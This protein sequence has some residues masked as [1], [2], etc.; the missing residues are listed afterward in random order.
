MS[1]SSPSSPSSSSPSPPPSS[2]STSPS[3]PDLRI[4]E[5]AFDLIDPFPPDDRVVENG[6]RILSDGYE[7]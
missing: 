7:A 1:S 6:W 2:P 4:T 5:A 3:F